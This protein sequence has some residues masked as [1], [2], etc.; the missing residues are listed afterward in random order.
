MS[1][2]GGAGLGVSS[3]GGA[4]HG[5]GYLTDKEDVDEAKAI[6]LMMAHQGL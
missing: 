3:T 2:G 4:P 5:A 1:L 6:E